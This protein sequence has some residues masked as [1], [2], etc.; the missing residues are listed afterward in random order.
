MAIKVVPNTL[1]REDAAS[2]ASSAAAYLD[3]VRGLCKISSSKAVPVG[4]ER[5]LLDQRN[6]NF[7]S[8]DAPKSPRDG[9]VA[10]FKSI[11]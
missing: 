4:W 8:M 1:S 10:L 11:F 6:P 5:Q 9:D 7:P 3:P 2:R